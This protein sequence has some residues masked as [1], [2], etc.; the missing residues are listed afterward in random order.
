MTQ[1]A[2]PLAHSIANLERHILVDG[3]YQK[4][5]GLLMVFSLD[6]HFNI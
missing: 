5:S 3:T 2:R 6:P 1:M 4:T